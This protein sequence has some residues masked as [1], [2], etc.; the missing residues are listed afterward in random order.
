M[1]TNKKV[2]LVGD[3]EHE[4]QRTELVRER[5]ELEKVGYE[6]L[7]ITDVAVDPDTGEEHLANTKLFDKVDALV[8][9]SAMVA[10]YFTEDSRLSRYA[11]E[12]AHTQKIPVRFSSGLWWMKQEQPT[13]YG[14]WTRMMRFLDKV[15][16]GLVTY[17]PM[18][19]A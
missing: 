5:M 19:G 4:V 7:M 16:S 11:I 9:S 1:N 8:K 17:H 2:L 10:N 14:M 12:Y 15:S 18:K 6:V 13:H 3:Y